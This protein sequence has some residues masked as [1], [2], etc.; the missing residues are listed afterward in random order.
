MSKPKILATSWHPGGINA[1]IPI[2]K[3]VKHDS[4]ADIVVVGHEFS[5]K[6]LRDAN[7]DH[8]TIKDYSLQNVSVDS[9][10]SL[11][12]QTTPNLV[13][14]GTSVQDEKNKQVI[15][16]TITLAAKESGIPSLAVL[17]FWG[18]YY[19]RF[20]DMNTNERFK[21]L[22]DKIAIMDKYAQEKMFAEGF[23]KGIS[24]IT[25][26]PHFDGLEQKAAS[27]TKKDQDEILG[28]VGLNK[29]IFIFY[30]AN[31]WENYAQEYGF[32]DLDNINLINKA[33]NNMPE[34]YQQ[35]TGLIVKLHPRTP[36]QDLE[37]IKKHI[38]ETNQAT[39]QK[40]IELVTDI[41]PQDLVLACDLTLTPNSTIA[42]EAVYMHKPCI[43][44]QP[45]LKTKNYLEILTGNKL[46]PGGYTSEACTDLV[47]RAVTDKTY[48][49][50]LVTQSS[51][52][53]TDGKATE[54]VTNLVYEMLGI[55]D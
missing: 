29:R 26:N 39:E 51:S 37:K 42:F 17:D 7:I 1:L 47:K 8:R 45:G 25:G 53:T 36:E 55:K 22:P 10:Q 2:V 54:R 6:I 48:R 33:I 43:S 35:R 27:F 49:E 3:R 15:E 18:N 5:E 30:A 16:Q 50:G 46:I 11:L 23:P 38:Q 12:Q 21:F 20:S 28:K 19:E 44:V 34:D 31:V 41:H 40:R 24:A 32:W 52:F 9:M 4:L 14:T 13:L